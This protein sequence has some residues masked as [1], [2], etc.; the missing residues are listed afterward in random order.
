[1]AE[2]GPGIALG[3][4]E[5]LETAEVVLTTG[6]VT[7]TVVTASSHISRGD[8]ENIQ[9]TLQNDVQFAARIP[10]EDKTD[11]HQDREYCAIDS[12]VALTLKTMPQRL[13]A[14]SIAG[15]A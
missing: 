6:S 13:A 7:V 8:I 11:E 9:G 5:E 12:C 1:M 4:I 3:T 15:N 14:D 10:S 2:I